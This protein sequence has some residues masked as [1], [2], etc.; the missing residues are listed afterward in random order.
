MLYRSKLETVFAPVPG[1]L[2]SSHPGA[3]P[4]HFRG[5]A[6]APIVIEEFA[7]LQ[8]PPC[9]AL[10]SLLKKIEQEYAGRVRVVFRHY[11][12]AM[13]PHAMEAARAVEAAGLQRHFWEM[14]DLLYETQTAWSKENDVRPIFEQYATKIGLDLER[15]RADLKKKELDVRIGL[16]KERGK[17]LGVTATPTLFLNNQ[18]IPQQFVDPKDIRAAIDAIEQGK[19]PFPKQP[20]TP[21]PT[22]ASPAPPSP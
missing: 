4:P 22:P 20:P 17:S 15:F 19:S 18:R 5:A 13:H 12:L 16:D 21:T 8:C 10:A 1:E 14:T 3:K 2:D 6:R 11:P 7:D 9:A